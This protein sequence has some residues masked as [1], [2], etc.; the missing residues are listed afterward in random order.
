MCN[1]TAENQ[2]WL[3]FGSPLHHQTCNQAD[4]FRARAHL[5]DSLH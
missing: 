4:G 3:L 2:A 5:N 1:V